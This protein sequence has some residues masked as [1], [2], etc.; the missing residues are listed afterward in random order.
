MPT[1]LDENATP[2]WTAMKPPED[3]PDTEVRSG[4]ARMAGSASAAIAGELPINAHASAAMQRCRRAVMGWLSVGGNAEYEAKAGLSILTCWQS[5]PA[6]RF[7][8]WQPQI[9]AQSAYVSRRVQQAWLP[10]YFLARVLRRADMMPL[11]IT[12]THSCVWWTGL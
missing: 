10:W 7:A 2:Y 11:D 5:E 1:T 12:V 9:L 6:A 4:V 8:P 3:R